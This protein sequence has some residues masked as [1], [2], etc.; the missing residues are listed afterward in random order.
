[1]PPALRNLRVALVHDWLVSTRGGESVL[2]SFC[3]MFPDA[4]I[5]TLVHDGKGM[6][7]EV[8]RT[9]SSHRII[10]SFVQNLPYASKVHRAL[11]PLFPHA[12]EAWDL[13][14]YDLVLS[15][16]HCAAKG[17]IAPPTATHVSYIHTPMR[18]AYEQ[19]PDYFGP[20][21]LPTPLRGVVRY[22]MHHLRLWDEVTASRVDHFLS[23]SHHVAQR[24]TTRYRRPST[25]VHPPVDMDRFSADTPWPRRD[26]AFLM[27]G[28]FAPYKRVDL[29]VEAFNRLKLPLHIVGG[30]QDEKRV[31]AAAG[32]TIKFLGRLSDEDVAREYG[33]ARAFIFPGE[34]DFGITPLESMASGTP[35][36]AL[37]RGGATETVVDLEAG[38]DATG[39]LFDG[40]TVDGLCAAVERF[41]SNEGR[42]KPAAARAQAM[43]FARPQF[44]ARMMDVLARLVGQGPHAQR[45]GAR[46]VTLSA[47]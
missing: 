3:R 18:Y 22:L 32:P 43:R 23:N 2:A 12:V 10:P 25:V 20:G 31:R 15:S 4:P 21:R 38:E 36:I 30:G 35:V 14:G 44:E 7:G 9:I 39:V 26:G 46:P 47:V 11:L 37:N 24:V 33:G 40:Q 28:A 17:V 42:F 34:E 1:L 5:Y 6:N 16:S 8:G 27:V 41:V 29:A 19:L 45:T 13:R